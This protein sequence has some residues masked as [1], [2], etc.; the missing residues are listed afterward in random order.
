MKK[1]SPTLF[2]MKTQVDRQRHRHNMVQLFCLS[3]LMLPVSVKRQNIMNVTFSFSSPDATI[4]LVACETY[5]METTY[6]VS[7]YNL[8]AMSEKGSFCL[9]F[10]F[11]FNA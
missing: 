7:R 2:K 8:T 9:L 3:T 10:N 1:V 4:W 6:V 11:I 5:C